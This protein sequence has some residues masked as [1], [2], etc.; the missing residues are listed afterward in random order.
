[1]GKVKLEKV[2]VL[3]SRRVRGSSRLGWREF[4][5]FSFCGMCLWGRVGYFFF[6]FFCV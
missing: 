5:I 2:N 6:N 1:M 3:F 4:F